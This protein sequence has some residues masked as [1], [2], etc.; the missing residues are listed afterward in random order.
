M[1]DLAAQIADLTTQMFLRCQEREAYF[2]S[3]YGVNVAEF[4]CLRLLLDHNR[5]PVKDLADL[6]NLTPSRL[7][8]II[9]GLLVRQLAERAEDSADRRIKMISLTTKGQEL[10]LAMNQHYLEMHQHILAHIPEDT[11]GQILQAVEQLLAAMRGWET[12][13]R[14]LK[15]HHRK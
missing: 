8:R 15:G 9:D 10:A 11:Q 12:Q 2:V 7:T 4:R 6:M 14:G 13:V 3:L 1:Q 5:C